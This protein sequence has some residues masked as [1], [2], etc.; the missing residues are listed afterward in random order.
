[1]GTTTLSSQETSAFLLR[2]SSRDRELKG[3]VLKFV[4]SG[5]IWLLLSAIM[6]LLLF[7]QL[8]YPEAL[9]IKVLNFGRLSPAFWVSVN[10]GWC[11]QFL[12]AG[13]SW[14]VIRRSESSVAPRFLSGLG[15]SVWNAGTVVSV[16]GILGGAQRAHWG[17]EMPIPGQWLLV[18][19]VCLSMAWLFLSVDLGGE[20]PPKWVLS[21]LVSGLIFGAAI[22]AMHLYSVIGGSGVQEG[23][24]AAWF[25]GAVKWGWLVLGSSGLAMAIVPM[26]SGNP[27]P[28]RSMGTYS[29]VTGVLGAGLN[30][31]GCFASGPLPLW[32][33]AGSAFG[34]FL[35]LSS[36]LGV[37]YNVYSSRLDSQSARHS[38]VVAFCWVGL[39]F[40]L[41]ATSLESVAATRVF[42]NAFG[43]TSANLG[44]EM[45]ARICGVGSICFG[46]VYFLLPRL[47]RCEWLSSRLTSWHFLLTTYG[48]G[49]A[50]GMLVAGG[51]LS[52]SML[53]NPGASF[54]HFMESMGFFHFGIFLGVSLFALGQ[55]IFCVHVLSLILGCGQPEGHETLFKGAYKHH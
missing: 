38:P 8:W 24:V 41:F 20:K 40:L 51:L 39:I 12:F 22:C 7:G 36:V 54:A 6:S 48:A 10:F 45:A 53:G 31:T 34:S 32:V 3:D 28:S 14:I 11:S 1:M 33:Q 27:V 35:M 47:V 25:S 16:A 17:C 30:A 37:V 49:L 9:Q 42:S 52:G 55:I 46:A 19:G 23:L 50:A 18:I 44:L 4:F 43:F 29:L 21:G 26:V 13:L 2:L 15:W 5:T